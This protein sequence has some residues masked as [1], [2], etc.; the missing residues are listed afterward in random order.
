MALSLMISLHIYKTQHFRLK[1]KYFIVT[2][3]VR[4]SALADTVFN[5]VQKKQ[6]IFLAKKNPLKTLES[7]D[8]LIQALQVDCSEDWKVPQ[9]LDANLEEKIEKKNIFNAKLPQPNF[10]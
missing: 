1:L 10:K 5:L 2:T 4:L 9:Q 3:S 6:C 7:Q 8:F